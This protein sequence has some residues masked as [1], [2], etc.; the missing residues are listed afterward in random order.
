VAPQN[1]LCSFIPPKSLSTPLKVLEESQQHLL[2]LRC[3]MMVSG[4]LLPVHH[5]LRQFRTLR[6]PIEFLGV[7]LLLHLICL[8]LIYMPPPPPPPAAAPQH[9]PAGAVHPDLCVPPSALY[10]RYTVEDLL[11]QC[12]QEGLDVLDPDRPPRTYWFGANNLVGRSVLETIKGYYDEAYPNW[13]K[14]PDH[15]KTTWFKCFAYEKTGVLP[16]LSNLFRMTH[17]TS[18]GIFVD[19]ASEKLFNAVASRVEERET[20]LTQQSPDGLPVKLTTEEVDRIFEEVAP[21]KKGRIVDIGFVNEVALPTSSYASRRDEENSQMRGRM[22]SQQDRLDSLEDPLDVMAV[23]NPTLQRALNERRAALGMPI[24]NP[25]DADPDRSQP[26]T[27]T[28]YF[29]NM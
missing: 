6:H 15:V 20:Q 14:T 17:A 13:I 27:A 26:S 28:D 11:A 3:F 29:D 7:L 18:D 12:G 22:D 5:L 21:R 23:G 9:V 2:A 24:R 4:H 19:P 25:E 16:S 10:A 1:K 8:H